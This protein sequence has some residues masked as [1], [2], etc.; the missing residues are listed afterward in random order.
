MPKV[1]ERTLEKQ[2]DR[3]F[4]S[5]IR[6]SADFLEW[7]LGRTKFRE[8]SARLILAR[9]DNPWYKSKNTGKDSETDIFLV[10]EDTISAER[11][12]V[13]IEN[14]MVG[15]RFTHRQP[16]MYYERAEDWRKTTKWEN[17]DDYDV[18]L[19][20]PQSFYEAQKDGSKIFNSF[21]SHEDIAEYIREFTPQATVLTARSEPV[22]LPHVAVDEPPS[23]IAQGQPK[24]PR[25]M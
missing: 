22:R 19:I 24:R 20:S 6:E 10:F 18:V 25:T 3:L 8:R 16:E 21:V 15:G 23:E 2:L 17:Y 13:H 1:S 7:F 11:F 14:K 4:E 12:A 5:R 9:A